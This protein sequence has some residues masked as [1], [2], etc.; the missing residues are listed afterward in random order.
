MRRIAIL[1]A[2]GAGLA[3]GCGAAAGTS[4]GLQGRVM[5]G[6]IQPV[7]R[8]NEPCDAPAAGVTLRFSRAG[9]VFAHA[10]TNRKGW[11][12]VVLKPGRYSVRTNRRGFE[13]IPKPAAATVTAGRVRRVDFQL[14]TG[15]R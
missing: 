10:T 13:A 12:R 4:S 6:P 14:D 11:Y 2:L 1:T 5:R 15:I 9:R 7:C 8:I 3:L